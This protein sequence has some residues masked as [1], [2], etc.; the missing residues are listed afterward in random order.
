MRLDEKTENKI[1]TIPNLLSMFRI[2]LIPVFVWAYC[3]RGKYLLTAGLLFVSGLTDIADGFIARRFHM[4]SNLGKMLDPIADKLTQAAMLIC[5]V[6]RFPMM[7]F[8]L[9]LLGIKEISIGITSLLVIRKSGAVTGAVWHGKV[10]TALLYIMIFVHLVWFNVPAAVS[11]M[12]IAI[13]FAMML[14]SWVLY[15]WHHMKCLIKKGNG[16]IRKRGK[17]DD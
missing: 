1:I 4:I 9:V 17:G 3:I 15:G 10:T 13:C 11:N 7:C 8:P 6:T 2:L 14:L 12:I 16:E 5:L